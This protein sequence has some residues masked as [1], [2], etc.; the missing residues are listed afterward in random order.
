MWPPPIKATSSTLPLLRATA[1]RDFHRVFSAVQL[2]LR[3]L[4]GIASNS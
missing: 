2:A 4:R 3:V 1:G